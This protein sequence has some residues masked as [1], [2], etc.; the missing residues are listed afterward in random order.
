MMKGDAARGVKDRSVVPR[1]A[2]IARLRA[3]E[4]LNP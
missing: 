1:S 3:I 2:G 4:E